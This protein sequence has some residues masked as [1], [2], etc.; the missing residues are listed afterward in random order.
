MNIVSTYPQK[1]ENINRNNRSKIIGKLAI[2]LVK[3]YLI[4]SSEILLVTS[5]NGHMMQKFR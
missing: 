4:I 1:T 2:C 5:K 3:V